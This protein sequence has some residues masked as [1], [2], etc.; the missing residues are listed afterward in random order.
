MKKIIIIFLF[1]FCTFQRSDAQIL[2]VIKAVTTKIIKALDLQVQKLQNKTIGLQNAQKAIENTL[3]KFKLDEIGSWV[4]KQ[5]DLYQQYF[6]ELAKVK[7]IISYYKRITDIINSQKDLVAQYKRGYALVKQDNHFSADEINYIYTLY[8]GIIEESVTNIDRLNLV[9]NSFS[10]SMTDADRLA[11]ING[12]AKHIEQQTA[13]LQK[14]NNRN[15]QIS[16]QRVK[17]QND[18]NKIK[19]L[20]GL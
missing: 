8:T 20:Y 2:E 13:D 19:Q 5:K 9:I 17:D 12:C 11:I 16:M 10:L 6:D 1:L 4:Q 3:S 18:L 14:L 7:T 15:A